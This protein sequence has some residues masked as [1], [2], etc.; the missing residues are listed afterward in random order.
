MNEPLE[1]LRD[2][3]EALSLEILDT[4]SERARTALAIAHEKQRRGMPVRDP[5]REDLLLARLLQHNHGPFDD[6]TV[7]SLF[8]GIIDACVA[9]AEGGRRRTLRVSSLGGPPVVVTVKGHTIGAGTACYVAGPCS[10]ESEEQMARVTAGLHKLGVRFLRG[11][12]FKPRTSPYA[13]QGLGERGLALLAA[14]AEEHGMAT[15]TEATSPQ[16]VDLVARYADIIQIGA[17]NMASFDLL[18]AAGQTGK[19]VLLKRGFGATIDEWVNAAEYVALSG[20]DDIILCERGIRTFS[21]DTRSTLDLSAVPLALGRTRLPV[22][23]DVS[24]A[25]GRRDILAPLAAAAFASG[26]QAVMIEVH[27]DP[28]MALSDAEQQLTVAQLAALQREVVETLTRQ[29]TT[30]LDAADAPVRVVPQCPTPH[31]EA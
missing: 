26:A 20:S 14:A 7:R 1:E 12:A 23:V 27:P 31:L 17:R 10:V 2:T 4:L 30:L 9:L 21:P 24:H 11:G 25:A 29:A 5:Q 3:I 8:R 19:P 22:A 28:D 15:I 16:N 6:A 18:R 13:F